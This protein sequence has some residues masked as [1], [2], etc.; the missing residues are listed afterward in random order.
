MLFEV[1]D[2]AAAITVEADIVE[3]DVVDGAE[4]EVVVVEVEEGRTV[5]AC[6]FIVSS[7]DVCHS[8]RTG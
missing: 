7:E 3:D 2:E 8:L 5:L 1:L 6:K 4:E